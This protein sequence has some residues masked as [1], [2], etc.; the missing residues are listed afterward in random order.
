MN[1]NFRSLVSPQLAAKR[2]SGFSMIELLVVATII[3]VLTTIGMVSYGKTMENSRNA[4]R[5]TDVET[6]RQA[7]IMY[8]SD[9]GSYPVQAVSGDYL[10]SVGTALKDAGYLSDPLPDDPTAAQ[11]YA[12]VSSGTSFTLT[13]TLEPSSANE[14]Y[15]VASP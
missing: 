2:Q 8:R 7:L 4:K 6:I 12:Y 15:S 11:Y 10:T 1:F 14:T 5:K 9:E 3:V 13:A